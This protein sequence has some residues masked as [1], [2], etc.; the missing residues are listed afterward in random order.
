LCFFPHS[1][2]SLLGTD[3]EGKLNAIRFFDNF[4]ILFFMFHVKRLYNQPSTS[5]GCE[6]GKLCVWYHESTS[7]NSQDEARSK[8]NWMETKTHITSWWDCFRV[9]KIFIMSYEFLPFMSIITSTFLNDVVVIVIIVIIKEKSLRY[10]QDF[11]SPIS[12]MK[13]KIDR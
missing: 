1:L 13:I 7:K 5:I 12:R 6:E 3:I 9:N 4:S 10:I 8:W 11:T 2:P